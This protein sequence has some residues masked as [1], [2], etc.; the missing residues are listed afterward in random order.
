MTTLLSRFKNVIFGHRYITQKSNSSVETEQSQLSRV[1]HFNRQNL[2]L[3]SP[4]NDQAGAW[5]L[6]KISH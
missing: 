4:P 6:L 1:L 5:H 3:I 2:I